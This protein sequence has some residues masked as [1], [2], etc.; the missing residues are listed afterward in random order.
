MLSTIANEMMGTPRWPAAR[1]PLRSLLDDAAD[2]TQGGV[3]FGHQ[4]GQRIDGLA[5]RQKIVDEQHPSSGSKYSGETIKSTMPPLVWLG[6][7]AR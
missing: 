7:D 2:A 4:G 1:A 5:G 6:A 3:T